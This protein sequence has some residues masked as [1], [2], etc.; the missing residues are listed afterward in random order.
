[1]IRERV[2]LERFVLP[3]ARYVVVLGIW[4]VSLD[5]SSDVVLVFR[6]SI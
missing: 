6:R 4:T 3:L 1:M 5:T 2:S